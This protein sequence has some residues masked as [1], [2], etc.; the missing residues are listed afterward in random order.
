MTDSNALIEFNKRFRE[1][2]E[3]K[4]SVEREAKGTRRTAGRNAL[5]QMVAER[6]KIVEA[7]KVK[8]REDEKARNAEFQKTL[9]GE[10]WSR[11]SDL[12]D[13]HASAATTTE[14]KKHNSADH[15][16]GDVTRMKDVLIAVKNT[17]PPTPTA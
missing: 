1:Q 2:N 12:I 15:S 17:P 6:T 7:R 13:V 9:H 16:T 11:V 10:S 5:K 8:N 14:K 3:Q 4:D